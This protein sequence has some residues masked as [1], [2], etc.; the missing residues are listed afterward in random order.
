MDRFHLSKN[1]V[2]VYVC[3][4]YECS[5]LTKF[6]GVCLAL[7][8]LSNSKS[9]LAV[10]EASHQSS[11]LMFQVTCSWIFLCPLLFYCKGVPGNTGEHGLKGDQVICICLSQTTTLISKIM[12][13]M[14]NH[15]IVSPERHVRQSYT[16]C[17][18]HL[19]KARRSLFNFSFINIHIIFYVYLFFQGDV[20]LPGEP[21]ECGFQG[22]KV[23]VCLHMLR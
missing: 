12:V 9:N 10:T 2:V 5:L 8:T 21:G 4:V 16:A 13:N 11:E 23:G 15:K 3:V 6:A 22:D 7:S 18:N 1:Y 20:G 17:A 19:S 14:T